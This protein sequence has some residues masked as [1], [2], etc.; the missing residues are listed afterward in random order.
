MRI[1]GRI[2]SWLK[3]KK[4]VKDD[5]NSTST[6][7]SPRRKRSQSLTESAIPSYASRHAQFFANRSNAHLDSVFDPTNSRTDE[8]A[9]EITPRDAKGTFGSRD[10]GMLTPKRSVQ[11]IRII[12]PSPRHPLA[13][14]GPEPSPLFAEMVPSATTAVT[15]P[16]VPYSALVHPK[17]TTTV[18]TTHS[19]SQQF[20]QTVADIQASPDSQPSSSTFN[21]A[22]PFPDVSPDR[23]ADLR[24]AS[25]VTGV[26][27]IYD[28]AGAISSKEFDNDP[29][30]LNQSPNSV[31]KDDQ[32]ARTPSSPNKQ[33]RYTNPERS[34]SSQRAPIP[35]AALPG[36]VRTQPGL[37]S[38]PGL[39]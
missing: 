18:N 13:N 19:A 35:V 25:G 4:R 22:D 8:T 3:P 9:S 16:L 10:F 5:S 20:P 24:R 30:R 31:A 28:N 23:L 29:R 11:S 32:E 1:L 36:A 39:G 14:D 37:S 17:S 21:Q 38:T 34:N 2:R 12:P 15:P 26:L 7:N 27:K 33:R 6:S